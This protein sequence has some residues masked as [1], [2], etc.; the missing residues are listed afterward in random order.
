LHSSFE[1]SA[2]VR[3]ALG[4]FFAEEQGGDSQYALI[5]LG[6]KLDVVVDSTRDPATIMDAIDSKTLLKTIQDS[7]AH[8]LATETD[9]FVGLTGHWSG[10]CAL[11]CQV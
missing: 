9:R 6:W 7:E 2:R 5:A 3:K 11:V 4:R 1:N 8:N 10:G